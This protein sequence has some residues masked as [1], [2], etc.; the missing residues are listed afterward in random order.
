M[1][2]FK[3]LTGQ[4][5]G[6]LTV[7]KRAENQGHN[8]MWLCRCDCGNEKIVRGSHLKSGAIKSC[9]CLSIEELQHRAKHHKVNTRLY[10]IWTDIKKRCYNPKSDNYQNYGGRGITICDEWLSDFMNFYNWAMANGYDENAPRGKCTIDRINV[11]GDYEPSNCRFVDMYVQANNTRKNFYI[12]YNNETHTI[13]E[14][15]RIVDIPMST[16]YARLKIYNYS[17]EETFTKPIKTR[18]IESGVL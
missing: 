9:G 3:D 14:W 15:G 17:I 11:N 18:K 10:K 4:K 7:I 8:C 16:L 5:F 12:T 6:R 13:S 2:N 1:S